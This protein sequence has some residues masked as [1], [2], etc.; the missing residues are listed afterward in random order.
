MRFIFI[1]ITYTIFLTSCSVGIYSSGIGKNVLNKTRNKEQIRAKFGNPKTSAPVNRD[2]DAMAGFYGKGEVLR[3]VFEVKGPIYDEYECGMAMMGNGMTFGIAE[4]GMFPRALWW[5]FSSAG[6]K[7]LKVYYGKD[8]N[9]L[10]HV[11]NEN[12]WIYDAP[13]HPIEFKPTIEIR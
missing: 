4:V 7:N 2:K 11:I 1:A 13:K 3:D 9:Y 5:L 6:N 10:G 8:G 12:H